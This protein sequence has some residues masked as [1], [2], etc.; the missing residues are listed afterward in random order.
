MEQLQKM[1][2]A[3]R[4]WH[5]VADM[6]KVEVDKQNRKVLDLI[7]RIDDLKDEIKGLEA[8]SLEFAAT[9]MA[10]NKRN[11]EMSDE[12]EDLREQLASLKWSTR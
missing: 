7:A 12:I 2:E 3:L 5:G 1:A 10:L 6:Y 4:H 9:I 8:D 11:V